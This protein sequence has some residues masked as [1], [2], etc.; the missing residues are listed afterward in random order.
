MEI[1][2]LFIISL[3]LALDAFGVSLSIGLNPAVKRKSKIWFCISFGFFQFLLSYIGA[4]L[5]YLFNTY[6]LSIPK[7]I[8]G[9]IIAI[10][11]MLMLKEG[12]DNDNS[13]ILINKKMYLILGISVSIDAAVIGFT[14]LN[15]ITVSFVL[16]ESTVFIG[17]ITLIMCITAFIIAKYL[18][19]ISVISKY[20]DYV[21]GVILILFGLKMIFL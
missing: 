18:R 3:A 6:I 5:G 10:V 13:N 8:G 16:L 7:I 12:V 11:G 14:A 4:F 15:S 19:K 21:G 20:A 1:Y 17:L 9:I 2:S